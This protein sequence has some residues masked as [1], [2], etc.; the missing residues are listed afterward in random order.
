MLGVGKRIMK[1][2]LTYF[3]HLLGPR[4]FLYVKPWS[5]GQLLHC[6]QHKSGGLHCRKRGW[7][8]QNQ[9]S[10]SLSVTWIRKLH[11]QVCWGSQPSFQHQ[12]KLGDLKHVWDLGGCISKPHFGHCSPGSW[13]RLTALQAGRDWWISCPWVCCVTHAR[14]FQPDTPITLSALTDGQSVPCSRKWETRGYFIKTNIFKVQ[15]RTTSNSSS[16][17]WS[18]HRHGLF[19]PQEENKICSIWFCSHNREPELG[20]KTASCILQDCFLNR[21]PIISANS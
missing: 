13:P 14:G 11:P 4:S 19:Q 8:F 9:W 16:P 6:C 2:N 15:G 3:Y 1:K 7:D 12:Q 21:I 18:H 10:Q 17:P 20:I 5:G